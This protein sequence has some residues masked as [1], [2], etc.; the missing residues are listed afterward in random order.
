MNKS[1]TS[2]PPA[3]KVVPPTKTSWKDRL[4]QTDYD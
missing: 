3:G 1:K 2:A 4:S